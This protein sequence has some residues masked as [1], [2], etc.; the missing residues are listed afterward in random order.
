MSAV[1]VLMSAVNIFRP[2]SKQHHITH[3]LHL[4]IFF[5]FSGLTI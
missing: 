5:H 1:K 3:I 2:T 4:I